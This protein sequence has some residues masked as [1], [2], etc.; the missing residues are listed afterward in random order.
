MK[1]RLLQALAILAMVANNGV[2]VASMATRRRR[3][4]V[5]AKKKS[6]GT[7]SSSRVGGGGGGGGGRG[8]PTT[9]NNGTGFT[10]LKARA[11]S[12]AESPSL[13]GSYSS[14]T[15]LDGASFIAYDAA[16]GYVYVAASDSDAVT[17][18]D[19]GGNP[20]SP[21]LVGSY[22]SSTYLDGACGIAYDAAHGYVYVAAW[23]SDAVTIVDVGSDPAHPSFVGSYSSSTYLDDA[24][25]IA[26]GGANGY[27][28]VTAF[29][30]NRMTIIDV[31][32]DP[33]NPSRVGS[34]SST[35]YL[36]APTSLA[37]DAAHGYV[38][39][40]AAVSDAVTIID[41]G[42]NPNSPSLVG[43]YSSSTYLNFAFDI[44]YDVAHGYVYVAADESSSAGSNAVTIVD[45]GSN[46]NSPSLVG[47]Y[48]SSTYLDFAS[49]LAYDATHGY[50]Y[51]TTYTTNRMTIIDVGSDPANPSFVSSYEDDTYLCGIAYDAA[52]GYVYVAAAAAVVVI[53]V[54]DPI[55]TPPPS[56]TP[57]PT[58]GP[59]TIRDP[60]H[61]FDFRGCSDGVAT[62]KND[63]GWFV[64]GS[65]GCSYGNGCNCGQ[66]CDSTYLRASICPTLPWQLSDII[67]GTNF[68]CY[69]NNEY[70]ATGGSTATCSE[71]VIQLN[72]AIPGADFYC[73]S[74]N[75][76]QYLRSDDP[77]TAVSLLSSYGAT[78]IS[79]TH[80]SS[81]VA[82]SMN[83]ASCSSEGMEFDGVDDYLDLTT[84]EFGGE[85]MTV[86]AYVK[87]DAFNSYSRI[88]D[89]GDGEKDDN[90]VLANYQSAGNA[91]WRVFVGGGAGLGPSSAS[92]SFFETDTWVHVVATVDGTTMKLYK[93][94]VLTDTVT[95][96]Q[97]PASMTRTQHWIGRSAWSSNG[98]LDATIAYL[99]FWDGV[100]LDAGQVSE[101]YAERID[102]TPV[103][104]LTLPPSVTPR[105]T[106]GPTTIRDPDHAFDFR[107]C[108][109]GSTA[110]ARYIYISNSGIINL[111]EVTAYGSS[112]AAITASSATLSSSASYPASNCIDGDISTMCHSA[113][114]TPI[115]LE[116]DLGSAHEISAVIINN[117]GTIAGDCC[118][119]RI[120]GAT[121]S[122]YTG[123]GA[124]G[125]LVQ[126]WT[127]SATSTTY[128][129]T[130]TAVTRVAD[131]FDASIVA[132]SMNGAS[133]SSEGM[134]FDG[135]DDYL[136]LTTWE[137]GGEP[138]TMEAF[139][140][141][142]SV[143]S[144][145]ILVNFVDAYDDWDNSLHLGNIET[146]TNRFSTR[147]GSSEFQLNTDDFWVEDTWTHVVCTV[148]GTTMLC[149]KNGALL[150]ST[151][152][153]QEP[154]S[155]TRAYHRIG[156]GKPSGTLYF[157][158]TIAY[159][160]FWHGMALDAGQVSGLYAERTDPTLAPTPPP[161]IT[162][163][164]T[165]GPTTVR[166]PDH[167]FDFRGCSSG[168]GA[169]IAD[170]G[171]NGAGIIATAMNGATC[172][173]EGMVLDGVN[174]Y[175]DLTTWEFGGEPM[176]MEAYVKWD[177]FNYWS[178]ILDFGDGAR[179]DEVQFGIESSGR[180]LAARVFR[181]SSN[182]YPALNSASSSFFTAGEHVHVVWTID[183]SNWVF[184]KNGAE[185][186]TTASG[187]EP[188]SLTRAYHWIGRSPFSADGYFDGTISYLR[189]W[190]GMALDA[191]QVSELYAERMDATPVP[192]AKPTAKPTARPTTRPT[193]RP[194][195]RPTTR[196][197]TRPTARPTARPTLRP[198]PEP[199]SRPTTST[200]PSQIPTRQPTPLPTPLCPAGTFLSGV[201][202][203]DCDA[204]KYSD[205]SEGTWAV[206]CTPCAAGKYQN[207][208][209][210]PSCK[211][212]AAG[213]FGISAGLTVST[214]SGPCGAGTYAAAGA[215][216]C[217]SCSA[218]R[219]GNTE[220]AST[221][222][223]ANLC[224]A[225]ESSSALGATAS[226]TC[227]VCPA[228]KYSATAGQAACAVCGAGYVQQNAGKASCMPC[229]PGSYA[230][231]AG[232][233]ECTYC[234]R[235]FYVGNYAATE[236][237]S[238]CPEGTSSNVGSSGLGNC[239][240]CP[241]G[242]YSALKTGFTNCTSC[243][244]GKYSS[245]IGAKKK[246]TCKKCG[247]GKYSS[248]GSAACSSC[249]GGSYNN[250]KGM[251]ACDPC[252]AGRYSHAG[253]KRCYRCEVG[254]YSKAGAALCLECEAGKY[255][256][257]KFG[258]R[259]KYI[260]PFQKRVAKYAG[261]NCT[262]CPA[263]R[264]SSDA[265]SSRCIRCEVGKYSSASSLYCKGCEAGKYAKKKFGK[266][267][268]GDWPNEKE[269]PKYAGADACTKCPAA[270]H[271]YIGS[272][273]CV[274]CAV[275]KY[276]SAG[277]ASCEECEAGK[278]AR[279]K[280]G[281]R[282]KGDWPN[283]KEVAKYAG[284]D[285]CTE[286]PAAKHSPIGSSKCTRCAIGKYATAGSPSCEECEAGK[287]S[288]KK[289]GKRTKGNWP[290]EK[291]VPKYAGA[292][293]CTACP[294]GRSSDTD[295]GAG[296]CEACAAG[297]NNGAEGGLCTDCEAGR[298]TDMS[299]MASCELCPQG[300]AS[301]AGSTEC[302]DCQPGKYVTGTGQATCSDCEAGRYADKTGM[303]A[304]EICPDGTASAAGQSECGPCPAG[305]YSA[306]GDSICDFCT[307]GKYRDD[308]M[309]DCQDCLAGSFVDQ[310]T[311]ASSCTKCQRG[312][313]ATGTVVSCT[314]CPAG[315]V[316]DSIEGAVSCTICD[317]GKFAES[318]GELTCSDCPVGRWLGDPAANAGFHD[319]LTDCFITEAG[320]FA[321][322]GS[323]Q[324]TRCP[325]GTFSVD[326]GA[327]SCTR[328]RA[329]RFSAS[330]AAS[331]GGA[332]L[333]C[334][335]GKFSRTP[336]GAAE[337][338][339]VVCEAG[340]TSQAG[341]ATFCLGCS[342][343]F[344]P[345]WTKSEE[346]IECGDEDYCPDG[347]TCEEG[348][349]GYACGT[350]KR[351]YYTLGSQCIECPDWGEGA[352]AVFVLL[353]ILAVLGVYAISDTNYDLSA[354]LTIIFTHYQMISITFRLELKYPRA[355][356]KFAEWIVALVF[357]DLKIFA[358]P[359]CSIGIIGYSERWW[360]AAMS[361]FVVM[362]P[363]FT[364]RMI[365]L[366]DQQTAHRR[367]G[368]RIVRTLLNTVLFVYITMGITAMEPWA[369]TEYEDNSAWQLN[370]QPS[371]KCGSEGP[372]PGM[373]FGSMV[374]VLGY[375]FGFNVYVRLI[376][377]KDQKLPRVMVQ[378]KR[379]TENHYS[380]DVFFDG[381]EAQKGD[382]VMHFNEATK[383][384]E[385][386]I[387]TDVNDDTMYKIR[388]D[389][390][391]QMLQHKETGW[392]P[393]T[394]AD[395]EF[396]PKDRK[397]DQCK[398]IFTRGK[399]K[400][401]STPVMPASGPEFDSTPTEKLRQQD[402]VFEI[403]DNKSDGRKATVLRGPNKERKYKVCYLEYGENTVLKTVNFKPREGDILK[404][405]K[406]WWVVDSAD[407]EGKAQVTIKD[408]RWSE[409][410]E[411]ED[412]W[413]LADDL[414]TELSEHERKVRGQTFL[415]AVLHP[416]LLNVTRVSPCT[417]PCSHPSLVKF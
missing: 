47:S 56:V 338:S 229:R 324:A 17:I 110:A 213:Y 78:T 257:E 416:P 306:A 44:V 111:M 389:K 75:G 142:D 158:G 224:A 40:A 16:H 207:S 91:Y 211:G 343:G 84:W 248:S 123:S 138:M 124:S 215:T 115:W 185:T 87:Y 163:P 415:N 176:T 128:T 342:R 355:L 64:G 147:Q 199:S 220:S 187:Q 273:Q 381:A 241:T 144:N 230:P 367:R 172:S 151:T 135:V 179:D 245:A 201:L 274:R 139:A 162:P 346:C 165:P 240:L 398:S 375:F 79:D 255:A 218:G 253:S 262:A 205:P 58:P 252:P 266:R 15:Y 141:M 277:S 314:A 186:D 24:C 265:G 173:D 305:S 344:W 401:K 232:A 406:K 405:D 43:S 310:L 86:E 104:T 180:R 301:A 18:I 148:S 335:A 9:S 66:T 6:S 192:T 82:T 27:V 278:Y 19:V 171:A 208:T 204:G 378:S 106:P 81:I 140:V 285:A 404:H 51:V 387:V 49:A 13:V 296:S 125:I 348:R 251:A 166:G 283:E 38:Y 290:N 112:G 256:K 316:L 127:A 410:D 89:F 400:N 209:G 50:V 134:E 118:R 287:Y 57:P 4:A 383:K 175:L 212:C 275:G 203:L 133:C 161:S 282:T 202:C 390:G 366:A 297:K 182:S 26:Y 396:Q 55:P 271:S 330:L 374:L 359:E 83:G 198:A 403:V 178:R 150:D 169:V 72:A 377:D 337:T 85:P 194:T 391:R 293:A 372:W 394:E 122:L 210:Q 76:N 143:S 376:S 12:S 28:Y 331:D 397:L 350:C 384:K 322:A 318:A 369:C 61:E 409:T 323:T 68:L 188:L 22:S 32:S 325:A 307:V 395:F 60:D 126:Q 219:W 137:F 292:D 157:D 300:K 69:G 358:S 195:A 363:F 103:P 226:S 200:A 8:A 63:A 320:Y 1:V 284:A 154:L 260:W 362:L 412:D 37:Y 347:T 109:S 216:S 357:F 303:D 121:V 408:V 258:S 380:K 336:G 244:A 156:M 333:S 31:G 113:V 236:C 152:S 354:K 411:S 250:D 214:C 264:Y 73:S 288:K 228:G 371:I 10:N 30:S 42:G 414:L 119:E 261:G 361:P 74:Q 197:T 5:D 170:S 259:V 315:A 98:Y 279:K 225:G 393:L 53:D 206:T 407:T 267:T 153:G 114:G 145:A 326:E 96:G 184:Y 246:K 299:G 272:S 270:K 129:L 281:K 99:R 351:G 235:G 269:V 149:Y 379:P 365:Q 313:Y 116:I 105:P 341:I 196:P 29:A 223:C 59:T 309:D 413:I 239:T 217:T 92:S 386:A 349:T 385:W 191:G 276:S 319:E 101:L 382:I 238:E 280:F 329:G 70:I 321:A 88:F 317:A 77:S 289:F 146:G 402:T 7:S 370:A 189:F 11:M 231:S 160:R 327:E 48:S 90:V 247:R 234:K 62:D 291:E 54:G 46:P 294:S 332:C 174:D 93:D 360:L 221:A 268:K 308:S 356:L 159:L 286:C 25:V 364:W 14:S 65:T 249:P 120:D 136:D 183:E 181:G 311:G 388:Y 243:I 237:I 2:L 392:K 155:M 339:C 353:G 193:A 95:D 352:L 34:Y 45:V 368:Y 328:C 36:Y 164:P 340:K 167:E 80:D 21:S 254:T 334:P 117:R 97:E 130:F 298:Y 304:C 132:T 20:N 227:T 3:S 233:T 67:S 131:S 41:V 107:G 190:D 399:D 345:D 295:T 33:A 94:G 373:L 242:K 102:P 222:N 23:D 108:S 168:S 312:T 52:H 71:E 39:V 100:A 177:A 35:T 417:R 263:A 302:G